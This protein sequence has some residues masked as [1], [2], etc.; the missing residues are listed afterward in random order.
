MGISKTN[1]GV[2][3]D[4]IKNFVISK[5]P[6][7]H[8]AITGRDSTDAHPISAITGLQT[9]IDKVNNL[10]IAQ[11]TVYEKN[12]AELLNSPISF[13]ALNS[14]SN[15]TGRVTTIQRSIVLN[16]DINNY[17]SL[18]FILAVNNGSNTGYINTKTEISK[19]FI[20]IN[21]SNTINSDNGS[22]ISLIISIPSTT[23]SA[24]GSFHLAIQG[25]FKSSTEFYVYQTVNS[26]TN[27]SYN[28][29][30][31][32]SIQGVKSNITIDPVEYVNT[33]SGIEDISVGHISSFIG[34][35]I[36]SHY[37]S[38]D[39]SIYNITDYPHL[40][41][42]IKDQFGIF[43]FFGGDGI[44]TFAVP[45]L[46]TSESLTNVTP[47]MTSNTTPAPYVASSSSEFSTNNK[48][49]RAFDSSI[50][51]P[52]FLLASGQQ[53][54]Y[55]K[56]DFGAN[57][58]VSNFSLKANS[59]TMS[60]TTDYM[61][62]DFEIYGSNDDINYTLLHSYSNEQSWAFTEER[63]YSLG[64]IFYYRYYRLDILSNNGYTSSGIPELSYLLND[65]TKIYCIKY[66]PTYFMSIQGMI[67]ETVLWE[68]NIGTSG[69]T[70]LRTSIN[71]ADSF[72]NYDMIG[73]EFTTNLSDGA[74]RPQYRIILPQQIKSVID[75]ANAQMSISF[76][77][78]YSSY[79]EYTDI[80]Y[81][82]TLT[83]L[84]LAQCQSY[85]NKIIGLK[86]KTF[87]S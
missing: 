37:L 46:N 27:S 32:L 42:Y 68:G 87:Q 33:N 13:S 69:T 55:L 7:N 58:L 31:I 53:T 8:N 22:F 85:L 43:N 49:Y 47:I 9:E 61:P 29:I 44:T 71:L 28:N 38:C 11:K 25:W 83:R 59:S 56:L 5:I 64:G 17:N 81:T 4:S 30:S 78:G 36:P 23:S 20:I 6:S 73:I 15:G 10:S 51:Q 54:G 48:A 80:V 65:N 76:N 86:F 41:Q 26:T 67:E 35:S 12:T 60:T 50:T 74:R 62:K 16:N 77:W 2:A 34:N 24:W 84:D 40:S 14:S 18:I 21:N 52:T 45:D 79:L 19:E 66:E 39:G 3:I 82:S 72:M 1:L 70:Q 63:I 57:R 75:T